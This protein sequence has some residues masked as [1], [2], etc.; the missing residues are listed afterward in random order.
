MAMYM[1]GAAIVTDFIAVQARPTLPDLPR[2]RPA[3]S[4]A[5]VGSAMRIVAVRRSAS[6]ISRRPAATSLASA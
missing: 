1:S 3:C 4:A 6:T 2:G 5:A